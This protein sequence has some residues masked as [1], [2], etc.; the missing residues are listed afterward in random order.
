ML[1]AALGNMKSAVA[2]D[3]LI[4]LLNDDEVAGH[5]LMALGKLK[6]FKARLHIER[7]LDHG[8]PWVRKEA[9]K[10]LAKLIKR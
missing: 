8:K 1:A 7:F 3:V 9:R 6:A 4:E 2:V 5:A 10:A